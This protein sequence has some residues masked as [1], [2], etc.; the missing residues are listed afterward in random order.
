MEGFFARNKPI[1]YKTERVYVRTVGEALMAITYRE[2]KWTVD[3]QGDWQAWWQA[4]GKY[5]H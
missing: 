4:N 1:Y 3:F 2:K 5:Y